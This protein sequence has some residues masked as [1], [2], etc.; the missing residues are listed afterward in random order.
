MFEAG[1]LIQICFLGLNFFFLHSLLWNHVSNLDFAP[2]WVE[3]GPNMK[4]DNRLVMQ[5][6]GW[7]ERPG[8]F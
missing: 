5:S 7:Q 8:D 6:I 2:S 3:R 1:T 4:S